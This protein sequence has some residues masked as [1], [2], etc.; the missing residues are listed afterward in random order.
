MTVNHATYFLGAIVVGG[1][2][3]VTAVLWLQY[4]ERIFFDRL[5]TAIVNCF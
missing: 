1:L 4:G 3:A 5:V 2:S